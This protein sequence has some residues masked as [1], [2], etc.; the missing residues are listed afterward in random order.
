MLIL[1]SCMYVTQ[2]DGSLYVVYN[3]GLSSQPVGE[4]EFKVNDGKYHVLRFHRRGQNASVQL[5][6]R[7]P[8][9]KY[10]PGQL[11]YCTVILL[12]IIATIT[13]VIETCENFFSFTPFAVISKTTNGCRLN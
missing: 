13:I 3:V 10:P 9:S 2:V 6:D 1:I 5:D 12:I 4:L 11:A 7:P 8:H